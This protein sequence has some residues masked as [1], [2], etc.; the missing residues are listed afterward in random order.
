MMTSPFNKNAI[1]EKL[2]QVSYTFES[3]LPAY[4]ELVELVENTDHLMDAT[5]EDKYLNG[6]NQQIFQLKHVA[7]NWLRS[8]EDK[9]PTD[10]LQLDTS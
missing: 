8:I 4:K 5:E 1:L 6:I 9:H 10:P 2:D 3:F 7:H